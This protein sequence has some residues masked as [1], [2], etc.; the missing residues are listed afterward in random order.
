MIFIPTVSH[1]RAWLNVFPPASLPPCQKDDDTQ[2]R[3][4]KGRKQR[5]LVVYG[6]IELHRDGSEWSAQ[7]LGNTVS[8]LVEAGWRGGMRVLALEEKLMRGVEEV[9][10]A[11]EGQG[12]EELNPDGSPAVRDPAME[13]WNERV[14]MLNG[15]VRRAGLDS[16]DGAW[17]GRTI[18]VGR[19]L[20]RWFKFSKIDWGAHA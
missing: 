4:K 7:G 12:E 5:L 9:D 3:E 20:S 13:V 10:M 16:K 15:S 2:R 19:I 14:P 8:G 18:E 1:L 17:S 11:M 6:L